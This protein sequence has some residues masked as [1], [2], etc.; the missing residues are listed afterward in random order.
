MLAVAFEVLHRAL[1]GFG[2]L[3]GRERAQVTPLAGLSI[4]L[5]RIQPI[6]PRGQLA[7]HIGLHWK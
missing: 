1:V 3:A 6:F 2:L 7:Y 4:F 5:A